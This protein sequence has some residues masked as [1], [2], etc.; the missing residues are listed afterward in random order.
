M[1][2]TKIQDLLHR[3]V[4]C[5]ASDLHLKAGNRAGFRI[6][7][8]ICPQ[9]DTGP[10]EASNILGFAKD[11]MTRDQLERFENE[12]DLDFSYEVEGL[13]R[14]RVNVLTQRG[15]PGLV[16]RQIPTKIPTA[17]QL[18]LPEVCI[19]L[20]GKPRGL[21][22]V[23]GP[24]GSGKSTTLAAMIDW[25]NRNRH[26][27]ILTMEDPIEFVHED[28]G[29]FVTQ[30]QIGQDTKGFNEALRRA[31]RQ[32]PDVILIGE[33]RDLETI[34]LAISAA[35]TGH[36]VF[37]TLH[38]TGAISTVDRILDVFPPDQQQQVRV[39]L[40]SS[41]QGVISQCL[42]PR[43]GGGRVA[44]H[45]I[46][47]ATSAV[48]SLI[49][50]GKT[51]QI[52]N[53]LQTGSKSGMA[54]LENVLARYV[55]E[56]IVELDHAIEKANR[57]DEVVKLAGEAAMGSASSGTQSATDS[58]SQLGALPQ[59]RDASRPGENQGRRRTDIASNEDPALRA[60]RPRRA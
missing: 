42:L 2:T 54:S 53:V 24:T 5:G 20:A 19:E 23:T 47:V 39:Q 35:E 58:R 18:C 32:D 52:L 29:C 26:G 28:K 57:P 7:G 30:R 43:M 55:R 56:R 59:D 21:V 16:I 3:M 25:I 14:F 31:L 46:L 36:L 60:F 37:G 38:T 15:S 51:P 48:R 34:A 45:E 1:T 11:M 33:M 50:E 40:S 4:D 41:L 12:L 27:H 8:E 13:A 9:E 17:E 22:L 6:D 10:F 44:A 49:R